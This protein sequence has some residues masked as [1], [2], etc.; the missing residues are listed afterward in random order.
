MAVALTAPELPSTG[1]G[2]TARRRALAAAAK[3]VVRA[4]EDEAHV[5]RFAQQP[6]EAGRRKLGDLRRKRQRR[7]GV[8]ARAAQQL[9][10]LL[11]ARQVRHAHTG[12]Q[13]LHRVR[14]QRDDAGGE[15][16]LAGA[17]LQLVDQV[18]VPQVHAIEHA[19]GDGG[20]P[21]RRAA[22]QLFAREHH[23]G[24]VAGANLVA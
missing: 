7:D 12:T 15:R 20:G 5:E 1:A 4:H 18:A 2:S 3:G 23:A 13:H 16:S 17:A 19:D 24:S 8:D 22:L 21:A 9:E 14:V 6:Q 11:Q 10:P